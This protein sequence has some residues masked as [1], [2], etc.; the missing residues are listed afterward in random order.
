MSNEKY[1]SYEAA[2]V[3]ALFNECRALMGTVSF[4]QDDALRQTLNHFHRRVLDAQGVPS[5]DPSGSGNHS[6][7]L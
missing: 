5:L 7:V 3:D 6:E 1:P 2:M 4:G